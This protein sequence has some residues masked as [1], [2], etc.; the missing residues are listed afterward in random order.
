MFE[1]IIHRAQAGISKT[2]DHMLGKAVA[3]APFVIALAFAV[4]ALASWLYREVGIEAGNLIMAVIF[5]V[6]GLIVYAYVS[7]SGPESLAEGE[8]VA[9]MAVSPERPA[10][11]A[12]SA[13]SDTEK[14]MAAAAFSAVAPAAAPMILKLVLR[15]LPLVLAIL[16]I[17]LVMTRP[18]PAADATQDPSTEA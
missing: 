15:N 8:E 9:E 1:A 18:A 4:A 6:I 17:V 12:A 11:A 16:A 2:V 13:W 3:I 5:A 14:E 10:E 7:F